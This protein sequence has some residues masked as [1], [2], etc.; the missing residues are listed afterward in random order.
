M[1]NILGDT[2]HNRPLPPGHVKVGIQVDVEPRAL[3]PQPIGDEF[4]VVADVV[5]GFVA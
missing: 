5:G 1:Y 2:L 3:L 4:K